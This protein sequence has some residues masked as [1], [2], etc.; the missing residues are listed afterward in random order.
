MSATSLGLDCIPRVLYLMRIIRAD[1]AP[2]QAIPQDSPHFTPFAPHLS[3][4]ALLAPRSAG[5][6]I[7]TRPPH[8]PQR[9]CSSEHQVPQLAHRHSVVGRVSIPASSSTAPSS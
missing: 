7:Q 9:S 8:L 5:R 2:C 1:S 3:H 6:P 4:L